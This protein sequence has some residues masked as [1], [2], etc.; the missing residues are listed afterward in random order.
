MRLRTVFVECLRGCMHTAW[1]WIVFLMDWSWTVAHSELNYEEQQRQFMEADM[2]ENISLLCRQWTILSG[3]CVYFSVQ[4]RL[5][6]QASSHR[7]NLDWIRW[8]TRKLQ[9]A[10]EPQHKADKMLYYSPPVY[11]VLCIFIWTSFYIF[12]LS[13]ICS[14]RLKL[15]DLV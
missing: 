7:D 11:I 15:R 13:I 3:N 8:Q 10:V 12:S 5:N 6:E 4:R 2:N 14:M 9:P 1:V